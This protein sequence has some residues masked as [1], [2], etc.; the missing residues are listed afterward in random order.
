M[1][2]PNFIVSVY[3]KTWIKGAKKLF[4]A[5]P[6]VHHVL[7][8]N[9]ELKNYESVEVAPFIRSTREE[10][11]EDNNFIDQKYHKYIPILAERLNKIHN[12]N[13]DEF[14]W[15]K[16]LA[17]GLIRY[18]TLFYDVFKVCEKNFLVEKYDCMTLSKK[19]YFIPKDFNE[20]RDFFQ[21]TAYGQEQ[22]FSI[23]I[24]LFY[25]EK[26]KSVA[27]KFFWPTLPSD[28]AKGRFSRVLDKFSRVTRAKILGVFIDKAYRFKKTNVAVIESFFHRAQLNEL[29]VKSHGAIKSVRIKSDFIFSKNIKWSKRSKI[30]E[31][32]DDFDRFDRF[33]F[34]SIEYC[35]PKAFIEDFNLVY[36]S[37]IKYFKSFDKLKYVVNES[38]IGNN[39]SSIAMAILQQ[40]GIK[41]IY[42]EHNF[43]SHHFLRNNHKYLFPLVDEFVTL[44]WYKKDVPKLI[45]GAS[46]FEWDNKEK[47]KIEHNIAFITG[48]PPI[49]APEISSSCGNFGAFNA[50]SHLDFNKKF[51]GNVSESTLGE[52]LYRGYPID[53]F[54]I[55]HLKPTM[56]AYDQDYVLKKYLDKVK[57]IDYTSQTGK[58]LMQKS[59]LI[60]VDYLSTAYVE[61]ILANKPT[62]FFWNKDIYYLEDEYK[63]IYSQLISA[64]IC[65]T[66][67]INAAKLIESIKAD[68]EVWWNSPV[69]QNARKNF[70]SENFGDPSIIKNILLDLT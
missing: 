19:S 58:I 60:I 66:D 41:H 15:K 8:K 35:F 23:Y 26:F 70:I 57:F 20:Q 45:K 31:I 33:F 4:I 7:E 14:F 22:V 27:D 25:P 34:K 24:S 32:N 10:L 9:D 37:Y 18:I 29:V 38:W 39:H 30:A 67:P 65:Q 47:Y 43:L 28:S 50:K 64:G 12:T 5:E 42:N 55:S 49:K 2:K 48:N 17:L 62:V 44:G 56:V 36:S 16:C 53:R 68:P 46:L 6:Y 40:K 52:M 63:D 69:V 51:F 1:I 54:P 11:I 21:S 3:P 13:Y 59:R 61:S